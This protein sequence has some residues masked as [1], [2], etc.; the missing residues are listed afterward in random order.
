MPT[1]VHLTTEY[2]GSSGWPCA[3]PATSSPPGR[4]QRPPGPGPSEGHQYLGPVRPDQG[5]RPAEPPDDPAAR[6]TGAEVL[7]L[8]GAPGCSTRR[9][10]RDIAFA[11]DHTGGDQTSVARIELPWDTRGKSGSDWALVRASGNCGGC[12]Y[13][14]PGVDCSVMAGGVTGPAVA[15]GLG[16]GLVPKMSGYRCWVAG[17]WSSIQTMRAASSASTSVSATVPWMRLGRWTWSYTQLS[18]DQGGTMSRG[19][20]FLQFAGE[21]LLQRFVGVDEA[22]GYC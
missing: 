10:P 19:E 22:A 16:L 8:P 5:P 4:A 7:L 2:G 9:Y 21:A 13:L 18:G 17:A 1:P 14:S 20:L 3:T 11:V 6:A 12:W 15:P